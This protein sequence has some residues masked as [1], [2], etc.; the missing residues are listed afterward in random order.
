MFYN[1]NDFL[2]CYDHML[3]LFMRDA[4]P[5]TV[6]KNLITGMWVWKEV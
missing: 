1:S 5:V 2:L 6:V 4:N 3:T